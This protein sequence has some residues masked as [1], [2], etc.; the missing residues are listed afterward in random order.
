MQEPDRP[1]LWSGWWRHQ[2][3]DGF[4]DAGNGLIVGGK[5]VFDARFQLVETPGE[6]LVGDE[7][8]A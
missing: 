5:A 8:V 7:C 2:L 1:F 3:A 4:K 6:I